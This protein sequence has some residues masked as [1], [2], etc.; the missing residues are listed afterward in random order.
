MTE[1]LTDYRLDVCEKRIDDHGKRLD[2]L[3]D[4]MT[5]LAAIEEQNQRRIDEQEKRVKDLESVPVKRWDSVVSYLITAIL[6][7][8]VGFFASN[9]GLQ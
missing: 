7:L 6:A 3:Q 8:V 9:I 4:L 5:R 1:Q 2:E